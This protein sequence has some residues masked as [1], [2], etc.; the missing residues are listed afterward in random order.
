MRLSQWGRCIKPIRIPMASHISRRGGP[1]PTAERSPTLLR[2][3]KKSS[4]RVTTGRTRKR[5]RSTIFTSSKAE[6]AWRRRMSPGYSRRSC[7][8]GVS[9]SA[10]RIGQSRFCSMAASTSA[11]SVYA[12]GGFAELDQDAR[13]KLKHKSMG[14]APSAFKAVS[15]RARTISV[16]VVVRFDWKVTA[17]PVELD[18]RIPSWGAMSCL[19]LRDSPHRATH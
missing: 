2:P 12:R 19:R 18:M 10:I 14:F 17:R 9:S 8:C 15:I 13:T 16:V 11:R 1:Q 7:R 5:Q 3:A 4:R 6:P